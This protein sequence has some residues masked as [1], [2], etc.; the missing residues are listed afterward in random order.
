[1]D[2]IKIENVKYK[3]N[4]DS[5]VNNIDKYALNGVSLNI[6]KANLLLF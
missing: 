1:M 2:I 3:Y 5:S 6:K 4:S